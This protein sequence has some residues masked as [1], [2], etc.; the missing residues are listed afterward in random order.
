MVIGNGEGL[1]GGE[2]SAGRRAGPLPPPAVRRVARKLSPPTGAPS[3]S[4]PIAGPS[5]A[6]PVPGIPVPSR[7]F[8]SY[9]L[10]CLVAP[11]P[12]LAG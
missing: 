11:W 4:A 2:A 10:S 5:G 1:G 8:P 6:A 12:D 7:P 9:L 3:V